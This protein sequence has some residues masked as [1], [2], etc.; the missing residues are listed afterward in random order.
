MVDVVVLT[1]T[2]AA[3]LPRPSVSFEGQLVSGILVD[4]NVATCGHRW[5]HVFA[6]WALN[7]YHTLIAGAV[8]VISF[9]SR[10]AGSQCE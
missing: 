9:T 4:L 6:A 5:M 3:D 1:V 2:G 10:E 7:V 8:C